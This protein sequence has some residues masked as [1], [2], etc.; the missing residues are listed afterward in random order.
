MAAYVIAVVLVFAVVVV[1]VSPL[2]TSAAASAADHAD[3]KSSARMEL[4]AAR[5]SKYREIRDA[6]L[7]HQ[8]G[9]LSDLDYEAMDAT[10][11]NEAIEI[12]RKLDRLRD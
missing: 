1:I 10:L 2:R 5:D 9:K 12:L 7:D 3:E 4:E 6:E 8:T 11:R